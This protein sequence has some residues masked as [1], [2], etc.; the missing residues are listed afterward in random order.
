MTPPDACENLSYGLWHPTGRPDDAHANTGEA[1]KQ[2]HTEQDLSKRN[3]LLAVSASWSLSSCPATSAAGSTRMPVNYPDKR[4][5][6]LQNF[7]AQATASQ[8]RDTFNRRNAYD[9][10]R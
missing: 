2:P 10:H 5:P 3:F 7:V 9:L 6:S 4:T 1:G 8:C